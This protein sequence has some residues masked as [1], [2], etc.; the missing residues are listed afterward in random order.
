[1]LCIGAYVEA[2]I[3]SNIKITVQS[4]TE[5]DHYQRFFGIMNEYDMLL[6]KF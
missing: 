1:M 3:Y 6:A 4:T 2:A 5:R